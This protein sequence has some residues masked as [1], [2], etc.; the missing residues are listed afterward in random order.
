MLNVSVYDIYIRARNFFHF[1]TIDLIYGL[2]YISLGGYVHIFISM[3][4]YK[5]NKVMKKKKK[6]LNIFRLLKAFILEGL[7]LFYICQKIKNKK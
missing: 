7:R 1:L 6:I 5:D 3:D 2:I 4:Y